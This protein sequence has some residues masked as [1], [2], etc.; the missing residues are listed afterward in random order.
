VPAIANKTEALTFRTA[1]FFRR[2][3]RVSQSRLLLLL[4]TSRVRVSLTKGYPL[5]CVEHVQV[6]RVTKPT[7]PGMCF[8]DPPGTAPR[9]KDEKPLHPDARVSPSGFR[10][11]PS[12]EA[13]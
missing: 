8:A 7:P 3:L 5:F 4:A 6:S 9:P 1:S 12:M 11:S 10:D 2:N 13:T